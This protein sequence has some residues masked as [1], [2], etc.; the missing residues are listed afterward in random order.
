MH[1]FSLSPLFTIVSLLFIDPCA[2][3]EKTSAVDA[4]YMFIYKKFYREEMMTSDLK[5]Y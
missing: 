2:I 1:N 5:P 4:I 3:Q